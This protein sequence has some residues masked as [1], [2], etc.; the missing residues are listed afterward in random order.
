MSY[1][2]RERARM[3]STGQAT[4]GLGGALFGPV[5]AGITG[6]LGAATTAPR[7][8]DP[9][10]VGVGTG[11]GAGVGSFA[12][13]GLGAAGGGLAGYGLGDLAYQATADPSFF[14]RLTGAAERDREA[15]RLLGAYIGSTAGGVLGNLGGAYY[16]AGLGQD[17]ATK[18]AHATGD[19]YMYANNYRE[20]IAA[21]TQLVA[22]AQG[23]VT[24]LSH[25]GVTPA[26]FI[27]HAVQTQD[28]NLLKVA[29]AIV[30]ADELIKT[31]GL[32]D[33]MGAKLKG[34]AERGRSYA[35]Q[36]MG[37]MGRG[38]DEVA[39][40][41]ESGKKKLDEVAEKAD[42]AVNEAP[43]AEP[44]PVILFDQPAAAPA[45]PAAPPT[46]AD[47]AANIALEDALTAGG[48]EDA[49]GELGRGAGRSIRNPLIAGGLGLGAMGG[50]GAGAYYGMGDADLRENALRNALGMDTIS[51]FDL[52]RGRDIE[53]RMRGAMGETDLERLRRMS[54]L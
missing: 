7:N 4:A 9:M 26:Q 28:P 11:L 52:L 41:A 40:A 8:V 1:E 19:D 34:L 13:T 2:D 50:A 29:S 15:A 49:M 22:Y 18:H 27:D 54:G 16:G 47:S 42:K 6:G 45:P 10:T 14:D 32:R 48:I 23:A 44:E 36:V 25:Y 37:E 12:G 43:D 51:R 31:G 3:R 24:K 17:I 39:D 33:R 46:A 21:E 30:D 53:S 20:K 35:D 38:G 5:G